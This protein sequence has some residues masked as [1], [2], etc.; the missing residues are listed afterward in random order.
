MPG[1][2]DL[3]KT[4]FQ[5]LMPGFAGPHHRIRQETGFQFVKSRI[6]VPS[7]PGSAICQL[8]GGSAAA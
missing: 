8:E 5:R 3:E 6:L 4:R 2:D 7:G 1:S